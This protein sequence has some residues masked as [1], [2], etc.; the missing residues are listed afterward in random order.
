MPWWDSRCRFLI[1]LGPPVLPAEELKQQDRF[2]L[3]R[4][5]CGTASGGGRN[6]HS[7]K[8]CEKNQELG[9]K[10]VVASQQRPA[11]TAGWLSPPVTR[12]WVARQSAGGRYHAT[13][14]TPSRSATGMPCACRVSGTVAQQLFGALRGRGFV[15]GGSSPPDTC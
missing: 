8:R 13:M 14:G 2:T 7:L 1:S 6:A 3:Q 4:G 15:I 10:E 5:F 11:V 9:I 12:V